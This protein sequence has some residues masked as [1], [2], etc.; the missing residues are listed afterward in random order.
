MG[1]Y[2]GVNEKGEA[3]IIN[4]GVIVARGHLE[5]VSP[6]IVPESLP[7]VIDLDLVVRFIG[8]TVPKT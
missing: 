4:A 5:V 1:M 2:V 6:R 8:Q 3:T 7:G